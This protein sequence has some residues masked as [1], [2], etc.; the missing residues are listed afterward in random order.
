MEMAPPRATPR[1][2]VD[3]L[4]DAGVELVRH[5]QVGE[6]KWPGLAAHSSTHTPGVEE[7]EVYPVNLGTTTTTGAVGA[8][9]LVVGVVV[10]GVVG[11]ASVVGS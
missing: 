9:E 1:T 11:H 3:R 4:G 6:G 2:S 5:S 8:A 10:V 7:P